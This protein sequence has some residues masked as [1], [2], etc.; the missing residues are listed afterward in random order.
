MGAWYN[1]LIRDHMNGCCIHSILCCFS[2]TGSVG[3]KKIHRFARSVQDLSQS[4]SQASSSVE[5]NADADSQCKSEEVMILVE[6]NISPSVNGRSPLQPCSSRTASPLSTSLSP[7]SPN[8]TP[9]SSGLIF[10]PTSPFPFQSQGVGPSPGYGNEAICSLPVEVRQSQA[11]AD[12]TPKRASSVC[13]A[14]RAKDKQYTPLEQQFMAI[15]AE[16]ADCVLFVECGY[17]YRFFGEDAKTA[18]KVLN[19]GCFPDHNFFTASIPV[20]RLHIHLRRWNVG[21]CMTFPSTWACT[22]T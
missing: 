12:S 16:H 4:V 22:C 8:P 20:H 10:T 6:D 17:K 15:K 19:I 11:E 3:L 1:N 9:E 7:P 18:S 14:P 21:L 5:T 13:T 2:V